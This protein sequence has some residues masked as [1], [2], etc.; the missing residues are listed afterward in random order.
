VVHRAQEVLTELEDGSQQA[1]T[2]RRRKE[3]APQQLPL[4][5]QKSPLFEELEKLDINSLTPLEALNKLYELQKK[6]KEG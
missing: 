4:L 2:K 1:T 6:A 3:A 5:G